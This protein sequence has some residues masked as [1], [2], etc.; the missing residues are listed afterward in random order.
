MEIR[1]ILS[2][3]ARH[4]TAALLIVLQ[5]ALT[6]AIVCNALFLI[7]NRLERMQR[8][9]GIAENELVRIQIA[10]I[11]TGG[12]A[13]SRTR[14]DLAALQAI[15][16]V[17]AASSV[18][19]ITFDNSSWNSG[20]KL[21]ADQTHE[22]MNATMYLADEGFFDTLGLHLVEGRAF[23]ADEFLSW[24]T[25]NDSKEPVPMPVA[26]ITRSMADQLFPEGKALGKGFYS[27]DDKQPTRIIGIVDH[28]ARP[29]EFS[30]PAGY[31]YSMIYPVRVPHSMGGRYLLRTAPERR[32]EV[33]KAAIAVLQ[34]NDPNR[35]I[36]KQDTLTDL[37][38]AYYKQDRVMAWMLVL[39]IALLLLVTALGIVGLVSFWVQQRTRQ[40][41]VRR[42]LG[43]TR[44]QILRYFQTENFLLVTVGIA[45]GMVLAFA[46]N[47]LLMAKAEL[48]RLPIQYL[49]IGALALWLLG[50]LAVLWPAQRA[51]AVP[52]AIATR[53]A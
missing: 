44:A 12:N 38:A 30:N 31:E 35:I 15:P 51:A 19:E 39:V 41:G 10:G 45:L 13:E 34:A 1:P 32:A 46:L 14:A 6:C 21:T 5:I 2:T 53:S 18:N 25:I 24:E 11:G 33:L 36:L 23:N 28:L 40:I 48:P 22:T 4:K 7:G 50:Q 26:V 17:R 43:A 49:P 47:Q 52:P 37:R 16:G 8:P 27:W 42:A 9:S 29:N 3:L 20:V